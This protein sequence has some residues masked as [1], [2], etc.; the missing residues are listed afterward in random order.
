VSEFFIV[1]QDC[2]YLDCYGKDLHSHT[3]FSEVA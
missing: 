2:P 1:D 3:L